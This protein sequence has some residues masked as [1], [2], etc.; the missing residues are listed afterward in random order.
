M[1]TQDIAVVTTDDLGYGL[2]LNAETN[3][4]DVTVL[5]TGTAI[6]TVPIKGFQGAISSPMFFI[7][8]RSVNIVNL[9]RLVGTNLFLMELDYNEDE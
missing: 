2:K 9:H 4:V 3:K 5:P 7:N 8:D 6:E 1:P